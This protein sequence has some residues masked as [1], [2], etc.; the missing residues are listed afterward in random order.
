MA[1]QLSNQERFEKLEKAIRDLAK[2]HNYAFLTHRS[3]AHEIAERFEKPPEEKKPPKSTPHH[4]WYVSEFPDYLNRA[5]AVEI[6][7]LR[8]W[9]ASRRQAIKEV[10][11]ELRYQAQYEAADHVNKHDWGT[12][13]G[14]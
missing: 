10:A 3:Y 5:A 6:E 8:S 2:I 13:G 14:E 12:S 9:D 1:K 11:D 4:E 7:S